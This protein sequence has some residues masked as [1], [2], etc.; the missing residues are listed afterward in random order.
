MPS[1]N[2]VKTYV[3]DGIYHIYNRGVEKRNIFESN[4]D[5]KVFLKYL[6]ESLAPPS[7]LINLQGSTLLEPVR[8]VKN[9]NSTIDL[10]AY[11]LMPNHFHLLIQQNEIES[12]QQ[13]MRSVS[14]RYSMYFNKKYNRVGPLFQGIYKA[15]LVMDE[16]YLLHLSRYIHTNPFEY[17]PNLEDAYS[18]Y[19]NYIKTNKTNWIKTDLILS[20]FDNQ[21]QKGIKKYNNYK[22]FVEKDGINN[23]SDVA[24]LGKIALE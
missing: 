11:C 3:K 8:P 24:M 23:L 13:F 20:F 12:I 10:L 9:F 7:E 15:I 6:K 16:P 22:S 18:S 1:R 19:R 21:V 14:T 17:S 2:V 5:Y 4:E